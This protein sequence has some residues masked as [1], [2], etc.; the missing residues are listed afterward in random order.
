MDIK[1][2]L[3]ELFNINVENISIIGEG[4]DSVA[5]LVNDEYIFK[6]SKHQEA[7]MNL[8]KEVAVLKYLEDKLSLDIPKILYYDEENSIC[9]YKRIEGTILTP[10]IYS[11]MNQS[12]QNNL[13]NSIA[14]F[15]TELHSLDL[16][17]IDDLELDVIDDY[18]SDYENL[19]EV[20][21]DKL[22]ESTQ[23]YLDNL[24]SK[25]IN[26][27]RIIN[28][29]RSLCHNDLSCNHLI[30]NDNKLTG[31]IDFGDV[32]ITDTDKDFV[33]L[34]EESDEELGR[35]FGLKVLNYYNH[36]DID[37]VIMKSDL[38]DLYYP[39]E[40]VLGGLAKEN[41]EMFNEGMNLLNKLN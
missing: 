25:I 41:Q 15:L 34:L 24:F 33:Y 30:I 31:I 9:G 8:K 5:Y 26:D 10:E 16:P 29:K 2:K 39:I 36:P 38:N 14:K 20:V 19:K 17:L 40:L 32:A 6:K 3:L 22:P 27:E 11:K 4:L 23:I 37:T 28:Y 12:E 13:A 1:D 35:D 7:A 21:Y 18:K